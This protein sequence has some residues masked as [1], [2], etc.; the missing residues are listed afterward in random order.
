MSELERFLHDD[1]SNLPVLVRAGLAHVQFETIHPFL[2]GNG[3]VGRLLITLLL[4]HSGVLRE[5]LLY[6]SPE[7][8]SH[9]LL[10]SSTPYGDGDFEAWLVFFSRACAETADRSLDGSDCRAVCRRPRANRHAG[11]RAV[12]SARSQVLTSRPLASIPELSSR[13]GCRSPRRLPGSISW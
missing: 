2:D 8:A 4:C 12:G 1:T 10:S 11:R 7:D 13:T 3:R 9:A 5:P 6:L